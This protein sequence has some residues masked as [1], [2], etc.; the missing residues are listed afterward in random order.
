M[1]KTIFAVAVLMFL[2]MEMAQANNS[3]SKVLRHHLRSGTVL[4]DYISSVTSLIRKPAFNN[5]ISH[6][7]LNNIAKLLLHQEKRAQIGNIASLDENRD[8]KVTRDEAR[9][10]YQAQFSLYYGDDRYER[11]LERRVNEAMKLDIDNDGSVSYQE[12]GVLD[13]NKKE[14]VKNDG[15][16]KEQAEYL[17]L[18]PNGDDVL[19]LRE[20]EGIATQFFKSVDKDG[21]NK[22]SQEE[23]SAFRGAKKSSHRKKTSYTE[24]LQRK[25]TTPAQYANKKGKGVHPRVALKNAV[26]KGVIRIATKQDAEAWMEKLVA[27][28]RESNVSKQSLPKVALFNAYVVLKEFTYPEGLYGGHSATFI[29]AEGAPMPKGDRGHSRIYDMNTMDCSRGYNIPCK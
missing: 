22:I 14:N 13:D 5:T 3:T 24:L 8:T 20:L 18:D 1:K 26:N 12:M 4:N 7:D 25:E 10:S 29:I 15:R 19:T 16:Y 17:A 6:E 11:K 9:S 21:D 23:Y 28:V 2:Q 27:K